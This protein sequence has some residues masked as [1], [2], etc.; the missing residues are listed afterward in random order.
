MHFFIVPGKKTTKK[1]LNIANKFYKKQ[2]II[3]SHGQKRMECNSLPIE[4]SSW[5]CQYLKVVF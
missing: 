5:L 1:Y 4:V 2:Q 3:E